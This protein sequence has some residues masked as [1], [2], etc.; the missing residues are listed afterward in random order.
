MTQKA[1]ALAVK[2]GVDAEGIELIREATDP[3]ALAVLPS[4]PRP[5]RSV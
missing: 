1:V 4:A 3:N 5:V 2:E